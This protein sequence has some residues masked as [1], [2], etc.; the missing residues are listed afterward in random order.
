MIKY[1]IIF[2]LLAISL[3]YWLPTSL[4]GD[5]SYH[6]V[7][8]D[9]MKGT[10][11]PGAFVILRTADA[12]QVGDVVSYQIE[13]GASGQKI[14]ILH[15]IIAK[16]P[17]SKFLMKGDAVESTEEIEPET[18]QGRM[19]LAIPALGFLP[20]AFRQAPMLLGGLLLAVFFMGSGLKQGISK[21]Q[22]KQGVRKTKD[23]GK[24]AANQASARDKLFLPAT[25]VILLTL[26]FASTALAEVVPLAFGGIV[27]TL[28][29]N[30]P[31]IAFLLGIVA[32]TR[33]GEVLWVAGPPGSAT[34]LLVEVNYVVVMVLAITMV[35]FAEVVDSARSVFTL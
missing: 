24:R 9:S 22:D 27:G 30:V 19:V 12:Y 3:P 16:L 17:D 28:L 31:L 26:P 5:T 10:L 11:D 20:G 2:A 18:V 14:T 25:L 29:E 33:L 8:T 7:L 23:S 4:G 32:V 6:F 34:A 13:A 1:F 15:R 35:P 21:I